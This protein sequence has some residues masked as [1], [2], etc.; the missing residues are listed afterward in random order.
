MNTKSKK[1]VLNKGYFKLSLLVVLS[2]SIFSCAD[3]GLEADNITEEEEL[4]V[5][6]NIEEGE[7]FSNEDISLVAEYEWEIQTA[8]RSEEAQT[9][10]SKSWDEETKILTVDF[11]EGCV[12]PY[13]RTRAGIMYVAF[14]GAPQTAS[15]TKTITFDNYS[16]NGH[17]IGG[18]IILDKLQMNG[19]GNY[20]NSISLLD[21]TIGFGEG[22]TLTLNGSRTREFISG[23]GSDAGLE[24]RITGSWTGTDTRGRSFSSEITEPIIASVACAKAG[25]FIRVAG[26]KETDFIGLRANR[27]RVV[28]YGDGSCDN[29]ITV[30]INGR[31]HILS[32]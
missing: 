24:M 32:K 14:D 6:L 21:Y 12:G 17:A 23:W 11:G 20:Y 9:C 15:N 7:S 22:Q 29:K 1:G 31:E 5:S 28:S 26:V 19:E 18:S 10:A 27:N 8:A 13:G 3:E 16:V 25:G 30:I 2:W 4:Q